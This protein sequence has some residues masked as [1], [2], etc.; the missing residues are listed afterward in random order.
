VRKGS[1]FYP[2]LT[3]DAASRATV[4]HA[5]SVLLLETGPGDAL[6]PAAVGG[7]GAVA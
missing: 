3:I 7:V 1:G 4:S 5:G 6:G 2:R